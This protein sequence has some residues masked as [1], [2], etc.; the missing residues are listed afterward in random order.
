MFLQTNLSKLYMNTTYAE[1]RAQILWRREESFLPAT[2]VKAE[3]V[4]RGYKYNEEVIKPLEEARKKLQKQIV[5]LHT[6]AEQISGEI[7]WHYEDRQRLL[8][9]D[10]TR[11]EARE[12]G[13]TVED[14][15]KSRRTFARKCTAEGCHGWLSSAWKCG[16]C[17]NYTCP[18][19]FII[20][21]KQHDVEHTCK[22]DDLETAAL[23]RASSKPCPKCGEGIEK[24]EGC[25][26]MFCTSCHTPFSWKTLE[27]I[28][29]GSVHNP[30]YFEWRN[31]VGAGA[32]GAAGAAAADHR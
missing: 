14:S 11:S 13:Q 1:N 23:I 4:R 32:A 17:D 5:E 27:I 31:R 30:H 9:G 6:Q 29:R 12:A 16:L 26:M 15:T 10:M 18:D 20:K 24:R 21:G 3:R 22:K 19:C 7:R 8:R 2:Q 28:T 25:D